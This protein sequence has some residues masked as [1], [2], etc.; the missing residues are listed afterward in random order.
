MNGA[1]RSASTLADSDDDLVAAWRQSGDRGPLETL[2]TRH[3]VTV[4]RMVHS[5]TLD[6]GLADDLV[7][8]V[9]LRAFRGL[10][11]FE[12]R[13][14]FTTWLYRIAMNVAHDT[15]A[16][17]R[18]SPLDGRAELPRDATSADQPPEAA[19]HQAEQQGAV[20]RAI[21]ELSP[22][23]RAAAVLVL[24]EELDPAEAAR[25][26]GCSRATIYWRLHEARKRLA[27]SL[28]EHALP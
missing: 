6:D 10:G 8:E 26:E 19:A 24:I 22:K 16:R 17:R 23:L 11:S 21:A 25:I 3:L 12:G 20:G 1:G 4:R 15:L 14:K 18:R 9:F 2:A 5:M 7:Q 27:R 13:S 28:R